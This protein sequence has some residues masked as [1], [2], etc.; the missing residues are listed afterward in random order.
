M[1]PATMQQLI[2][3]LRALVKQPGGVD[4]HFQTTPNQMM[5]GKAPA[6]TN[7]NPMAAVNAA[8]GAPSPIMGGQFNDAIAG[9]FGSTQKPMG[10]DQ[11]T[12]GNAPMNFSGMSSYGGG[13][14]KSQSIPKAKRL[15]PG[16]YQGAD[17]KVVK[18]KN[19]PR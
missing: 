12:Y 8:A 19:Q 10:M 2:E 17:G 6:P 3:S 15:S 16:M 9:A 1:D 11:G 5:N 14:G 7:G 4:P 18:S 13:A